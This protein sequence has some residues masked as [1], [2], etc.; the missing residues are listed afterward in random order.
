MISSTV[1]ALQAPSYRYSRVFAVGFEA[2]CKV[3]LAGQPDDADREAIRSS[4]CIGLGMDPA[5]VR[6]DSEELLASAAGKS[7]AE[8]LASDDFTSIGASKFKYTYC[9]GAGL[10][11]LMTTVGVEPD[12]AAIDEWCGSLN[13]PSRTLQRDWAYYKTSLE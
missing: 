2:L 4:M 6:R 12:D 7:A 13:M 1:F 3:F 10:T 8:L 5:M 11:T 9:F